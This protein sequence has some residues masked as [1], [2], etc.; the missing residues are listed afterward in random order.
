MTLNYLLILHIFLQKMVTM[1]TLVG[2]EGG[3]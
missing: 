2:V 3:K 1:V